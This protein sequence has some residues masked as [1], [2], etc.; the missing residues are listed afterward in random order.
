MDENTLN[1]I[2]KRNFIDLSKFHSKSFFRIQNLKEFNSENK[3]ILC[4]QNW[5]NVYGRLGLNNSLSY[6]D[7]SFQVG[8]GTGRIENW[9]STLGGLTFGFTLGKN[10]FMNDQV[11]SPSNNYSYSGTYTYTIN[12]VLFFEGI[13]EIWASDTK[14]VRVHVD[15]CSGEVTYSVVEQ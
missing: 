13:G 1:E 7:I 6:I 8:T 10:N 2:L 4:L 9:N 5:R 11:A 14:K 3:A 15:A 12:Y